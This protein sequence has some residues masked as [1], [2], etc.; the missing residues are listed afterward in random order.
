MSFTRKVVILSTLSVLVVFFTV[1]LISISNKPKK[2]DVD[3]CAIYRIIYET[4]ILSWV[5]DGHKI[6]IKPFTIP[7]NDVLVYG[8]SPPNM[9]IRDTG[10]T[11]IVT[12][13]GEPVE[14]MVTEEFEF[15][16][17]EFF[18]GKFS[19]KTLNIQDCYSDV[20]TSPRLE[21]LDYKTIMKY[22]KSYAEEDAVFTSLWKFSA[23]VFS[24]DARFAIVYVEYFCGGLCGEGYYMLVKKNE[25]GWSLMGI[26]SI[27]IS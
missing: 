27:W 19:T 25:K 26:H 12:S 20:D 14:R 9:F 13:F 21:D 1:I 4:D 5:K 11:K 2:A 6:S 3:S 7:D 18:T 23:P 24:E 10:Q 17:S 15:D 8:S 22:E 16:S